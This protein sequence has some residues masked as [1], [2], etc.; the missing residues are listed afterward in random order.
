VS[1]QLKFSVIL[2]AVFLAVFLFSGC[3]DYE[4]QES[5]SEVS[6]LEQKVENYQEDLEE[7]N[8]NIEAGNDM[9][10]QIMDTAESISSDYSWYG[11]REMHPIFEDLPYQFRN[12]NYHQKT[13]SD[14]N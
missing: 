4:L 8:A 1:R 5:I 12:Y 11:C 14:P 10:D 9:I 3:S 2:G 6:E 7:A 13:I